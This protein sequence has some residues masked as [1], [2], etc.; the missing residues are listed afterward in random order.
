MK[1][2]YT[3]FRTYR[4]KKNICSNV[5]SMS[6]HFISSLLSSIGPIL[7]VLLSLYLFHTLR[8]TDNGILIVLST[9]ILLTMGIII[10]F[11]IY[12]YVI[13]K[14]HEN[15]EKKDL[16]LVLRF[17]STIILLIIYMIGLIYLLI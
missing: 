4:Y 16:K 7:S 6:S 5:I 10:Y 11:I 9:H 14:R 17:E 15:L 8:L 12:Y 3:L 2:I 13:I 1:K